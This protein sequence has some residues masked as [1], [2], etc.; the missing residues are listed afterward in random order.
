MHITLYV[1]GGLIDHIYP[2]GVLSWVP[3]ET[4][5]RTSRTM[6][7][8]HQKSKLQGNLQVGGSMGPNE[9]IYE[10]VGSEHVF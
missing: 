8:F 2:F 6:S 5:I 4:I 9:H 7:A 1:L 3:I 10:F